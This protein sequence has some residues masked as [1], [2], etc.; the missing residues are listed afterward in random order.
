MKKKSLVVLGL[1]VGMSLSLPLLS[2]A[3]E[4]KQD[5][6]GWWLQNDDGTYPVNKWEWVDGN[7]D[8]I[9]ECYYF[10][11]SGYCLMA[12]TTPD[13]CTVNESGAW[14]VNGVVQTKIVNANVNISS[15]T[16]NSQ[17][18]YEKYPNDKDIID[19]L[20]SLGYNDV[21][22]EYYFNQR[23]LYGVPESTQ[24]N[25]GGYSSWEEYSRNIDLS[26]YYFNYTD[27]D[28]QRAADEYI[29]D[30]TGWN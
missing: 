8:G 17:D 3:G 29:P 26:K 20:K 1:A 2:Y 25:Y 11:E 19:E 14:I 22:I 21:M 24:N 28:V 4:W 12:T 6:T 5:A 23:D 30:T 18:L 27:E 13:N 9:A 7:K 16:N 10:N 15:N